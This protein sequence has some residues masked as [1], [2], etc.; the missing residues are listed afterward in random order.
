MVHDP[1]KCSL[2]ESLDCSCLSNATIVEFLLS[3]VWVS[4]IE[5]KRRGGCGVKPVLDICLLEAKRC[6]CGYNGVVSC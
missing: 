4:C 5:R 3:S 1:R 2:N 6:K